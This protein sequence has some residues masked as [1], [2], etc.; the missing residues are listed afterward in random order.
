[1]YGVNTIYSAYVRHGNNAEKIAGP[2]SEG[3][4]QSK[5]SRFLSNYLIFPD[6]TKINRTLQCRGQFRFRNRLHN[7]YFYCISKVPHLYIR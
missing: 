3:L 5:R 1:M 7:V 4:E 2:F 6:V